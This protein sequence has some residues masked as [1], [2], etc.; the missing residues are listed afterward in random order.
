M[1]D[2]TEY[3]KGFVSAIIAFAIGLSLATY[4]ISLVGNVTGIPLLTT[5]LVGTVIGGGLL[6]F[7]MKTFF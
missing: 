1:A 5:A 4:I 3:V 7:L 2:V 6:L